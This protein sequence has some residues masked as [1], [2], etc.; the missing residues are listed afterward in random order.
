MDTCSIYILVRSIH[1]KC[2]GLHSLIFH[3]LVLTKQHNGLRHNDNC[4]YYITSPLSIIKVNRFWTRTF[5]LRLTQKRTIFNVQ[6]VYGVAKEKQNCSLCP[7]MSIKEHHSSDIDS[8]DRI[9]N[10]SH[11]DIIH[12]HT[13]THIHFIRH[14][15]FRSSHALFNW[16]S[17]NF[18]TSLLTLFFC[19]VFS[20]KVKVKCLVS[21]C[22]VNVIMK[23]KKT[24]EINLL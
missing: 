3:I 2:E 4:R 14:F 6:Y 13:H 17:S 24:N 12:R 18:H 21:L 1:F 20:E 10:C 23:K 19:S 15:Q 8:S 22:N 5:T 16:F 11:N 9:S 7:N